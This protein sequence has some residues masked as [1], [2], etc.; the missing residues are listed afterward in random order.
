MFELL[1]LAGAKESGIALETRLRTPLRNS[2]APEPDAHRIL[3]VQHL[4]DTHP[5][6][7]CRKAACGIYRGAIS[8]YQEG[9][10]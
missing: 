5:Q 9:N 4:M 3:I 8:I 2:Q 6:W 10:R 1:G 7:Q